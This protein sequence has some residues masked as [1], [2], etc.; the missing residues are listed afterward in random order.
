MNYLS[1]DDGDFVHFHKS[2]DEYNARVVLKTALTNQFEQYG[3]RFTLKNIFQNR[4]RWLGYDVDKDH[5]YLRGCYTKDGNTF[6]KMD[7]DVDS[8]FNIISGCLN[9]M[10]KGSFLIVKEDYSPFCKPISEFTNA[11]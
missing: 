2:E 4:K 5:I 9:Y 3:T 6:K 11:D 8:M 10:R 7:N 1:Y